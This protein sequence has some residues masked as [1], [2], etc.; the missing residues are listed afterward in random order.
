ML[1]LPEYDL[2]NNVSTNARYHSDEFQYPD[3]L[4]YTGETEA[5]DES[6]ILSSSPVNNMIEE[7]VTYLSLSQIA[8]LTTP[9]LTIEE[10]FTKYF[11]QDSDRAAYSKVIDYDTR[12]REQIAMLVYNAQ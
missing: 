10:E 8:L 1:S 11:T 4:Q 5:K 12:K 9:A 3:L 6:D 2:S 7:E